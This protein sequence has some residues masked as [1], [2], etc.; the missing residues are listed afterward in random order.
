MLIE[1]QRVEIDAVFESRVS[2]SRRLFSW[3]AMSSVM[4]V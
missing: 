3:D 1:I 2:S 4:E